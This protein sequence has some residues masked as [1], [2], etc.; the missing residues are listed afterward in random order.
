[1]QTDRQTGR[2]VCIQT[3]RQAC[4]HANKQTGRQVSMQTGRQTGRQAGRELRTRSPFK[5]SSRV[6]VVV[7]YKAGLSATIFFANFTVARIFC[8][9]SSSSSSSSSFFAGGGGGGGGGYIFI[10][11]FIFLL[12]ALNYW[13]SFAIKSRDSILASTSAV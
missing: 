6:Y 3:D 11:Y 1:M 8:T 12:T 13:C 10:E 5:T 2:Q 9:F 7:S 4:V